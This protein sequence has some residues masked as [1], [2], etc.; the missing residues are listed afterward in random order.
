MANLDEIAA[1]FQKDLQREKRYLK[2]K[3]ELAFAQKVFGELGVLVGCSK[4]FAKKLVNESQEDLAYDYKIKFPEVSH[5]DTTASIMSNWKNLFTPV[6]DW[7]H[8]LWGQFLRAVDTAKREYGR[9]EAAL[10]FRVKQT[11]WIMTS[12]SLGVPQL[13]PVVTVTTK[14]GLSEIRVMPLAGYIK[15][16][17]KNT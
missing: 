17:E 4:G 16:L 8:D 6:R 10:V 12:E 5:V 13:T 14:S 2:D 1:S 3:S 7:P 15:I 11:P 9:G